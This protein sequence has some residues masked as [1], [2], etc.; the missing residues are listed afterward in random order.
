MDCTKCG[1]ANSPGLSACAY[2]G[3]AFPAAPAPDVGQQLNNSFN[4]LLQGTGGTR[5]WSD[6]K[7]Y[8]QQA[9]AE[10]ERA[11]GTMT[12][13]WNWAAFLFGAIWYLVRGMPLKGIGIILLTLISG[14][15]LGFFL[16]IYAGLFGT[17]DFYLLKAK[18]KQL[19]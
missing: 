12:A 13:K 6:L 19:W 2:C 11:G 5:D 3:A 1:A 15:T 17:Y 7:P 18:G 10:I 16:W 4:T 9:F 14:G 8:Y